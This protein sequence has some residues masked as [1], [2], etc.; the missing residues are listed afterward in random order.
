MVLRSPYTLP[1]PYAH[2]THTPTHAYS[3]DSATHSAASPDG[4]V[5]LYFDDSESWRAAKGWLVARIQEKKL[6]EQ[7]E[8]AAAV[9][10]EKTD[11]EAKIQEEEKEDA[12][13]ATLDTDIGWDIDDAIATA[14]PVITEVA[15]SVETETA[16]PAST[17]DIAVMVEETHGDAQQEEGGATTDTAE[18][19]TQ[20]NNPDAAGT[21]TDV[22][23]ADQSG[24]AGEEAPVEAPVGVHVPAETTVEASVDTPV[25]ARPTS[26]SRLADAPEAKTPTAGS[27]LYKNIRQRL[28]STDNGQKAAGVSEGGENS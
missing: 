23:V 4:K 14:P 12:A 15:G 3:R 20:S 11:P 9:A 18:V 7:E 19:A 1:N 27:P 2:H 17:D 8:A 16:P 28:K 6:E 13:M 21:G 26:L 22:V 25:K 24:S 5:C 10:E